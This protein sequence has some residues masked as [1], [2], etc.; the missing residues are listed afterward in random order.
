MDWQNSLRL[1]NS[2]LLGQ[3]EYNNTGHWQPLNLSM[4]RLSRRVGRFE[5]SESG[6]LVMPLE[7]LT[8]QRTNSTFQRSIRR[9]SPRSTLT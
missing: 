1:M 7:S 9:F 2:S 5:L 3:R 6:L 4:Q 8:F